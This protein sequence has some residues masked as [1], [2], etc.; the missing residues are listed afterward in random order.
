M[1]K[2]L[3]VLV[4]LVSRLKGSKLTSTD[5]RIKLDELTA[6][7]GSGEEGFDKCDDKIVSP[8]DVL[9]A[10]SVKALTL[11]HT[12]ILMVLASPDP[13]HST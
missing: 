6:E 11:G 5:V 3:S 2:I 4:S 12:S 10:M 7:H 9:R 13:E 8:S 1:L